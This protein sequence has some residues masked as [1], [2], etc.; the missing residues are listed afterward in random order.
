M[1]SMDIQYA[2]ISD[3]LLARH[4]GLG[5]IDMADDFKAES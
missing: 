4:D 5:L 3:V 2:G 1:N